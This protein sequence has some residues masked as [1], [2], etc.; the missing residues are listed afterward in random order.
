MIP[1]SHLPRVV[2]IAALLGALG[3]GYVL[4]DR[5]P[6][7]HAEPAS[8]DPAEAEACR[9]ACERSGLRLE[10]TVWERG[11]ALT[12]VCSAGGAE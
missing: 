8:Y 6:T 7:V 4:A 1:D 10:G 12:C 3:L 2:L 9:D 11:E 5:D